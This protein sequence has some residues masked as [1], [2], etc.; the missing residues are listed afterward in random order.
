MTLLFVLCCI[1]AFSV[2]NARP[3]VDYTEELQSDA[4]LAK[5]MVAQQGNDFSA[6]STALDKLFGVTPGS[7]LQV[8]APTPEPEKPKIEYPAGE[9]GAFNLISKN[10]IANE[11]DDEVLPLLAAS[12]MREELRIPKRPLKLLTTATGFHSL[13]ATEKIAPNQIFMSAR[14]NDLLI[15]SRPHEDIRHIFYDCKDVTLN[16]TLYRAPNTPFA[17]MWMALSLLYERSLG[18][19]SHYASYIETL[20][21][22]F[23]TPIHWSKEELDELAGSSLYR[24]MVEMEQLTQKHW[25]LGAWPLLLTVYPEIFVPR[26]QFFTEDAF[27]WAFDIVETRAFGLEIDGFHTKVLA[28]LIDMFNHGMK[29]DGG[30]TAAWDYND[31]RFVLVAQTPFEMGDE[32]TICYGTLNNVALL[33]HYGFTLP[34]NPVEAKPR[35]YEVKDKEQMEKELATFHTTHEEDEQLL[36]KVS[37]LPFNTRNALILRMEER[38]AIMGKSTKTVPTLKKSLWRPKKTVIQDKLDMVGIIKNKAET[39]MAKAMS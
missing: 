11:T 27:K 26:K 39:I 29:N 31:G 5:S 1:A 38:E 22:N 4:Q 6:L 30:A 15:S 21:V 19:D 37:D 34:N 7:G 14:I 23:S 3:A 25:F 17:T 13:K 20:P 24:E 8:P 33:S 18:K 9:L 10:R 12:K 35:P 28:P 32:V 2:S 16:N 36:Q